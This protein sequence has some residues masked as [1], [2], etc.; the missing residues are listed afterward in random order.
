M[1]KKMLAVA[2]G[3]AMAASVVSSAAMAEE[4]KST[5]GDVVAN[6]EYTFEIIVKSYS[7]DFWLAV[8]EGAQD[9]AEL[10]GVK[11]ICNGPNSNTDSADQ[12]QM[13]NS[14]ING[15][16]DGVGI[17]AID[18][19][20]CY[21]SMQLALDQGVPVVCFNS[22]IPGAVEGSVYATATTDNFEA[23]GIGAEHMYEA[24]KD[25]IANAT[26]PVRIGQVN[27]DAT[28]TS[29]TERGIG[30]IDKM[31]ELCKAD[32]KSVAVI[33]NEK[34]MSDCTDA[35]DE[36]TADVIIE[37]RVPAQATSELCATEASTLLNKE[38]LIGIIGTNQETAEG[39]LTA[40]QNIGKLGT[41]I[42]SGQVIGCGFDSGAVIVDAVEN[43]ILY[44][45]ITQAPRYQGQVT[46]DLLTM[47]ANGEEVTDVSTPV[48]WY[49]SEN[50]NDPEIAPNLIR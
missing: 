37:V 49:N 8:V 34:Y 13:L 9:E 18:K 15:D 14:A 35:G 25:T 23:G 32:G 48:Y 42:A 31:I 6:E 5:Y 45:A 21:D 11:V 46:V 10:L 28:S 17:A 19:E 29:V 12:I 43:N 1:K 24:L 2:L 4:A 27:Q 36:S 16:A 41:D 30:F 40:D 26:E 20:A 3:T 7:S 22:G 39:I 38:D 47:I 33:G 50:M 44:G